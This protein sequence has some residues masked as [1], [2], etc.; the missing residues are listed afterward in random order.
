MGAS[1]FRLLTQ[2]YPELFGG[3]G[4]FNTLYKGLNGNG[5]SLALGHGLVLLSTDWL[6]V[7][8][9]FVHCD[10]FCIHGPSHAKTVAALN[11][12]IDRAND[13]G[14]LFNPTKVNPPSHR[15]KYCSFIYDT[16]EMPTLRNY[17]ETRREGQIS[18]LALSVVTGLLQFLVDPSRSRT[19]Q[20]DGTDPLHPRQRLYSDFGCRMGGFVVVARR[21][22][23]W[24]EPTRPLSRL[25]NFGYDLG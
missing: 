4:E 2:E 3:V 16:P 13:V 15:A 23:E 5:Y 18:R 21:F 24:C 6:P 12:L 10:Y 9:I 8:K 14:L 11:A 17:M 7:V 1:F 25:R 20:I 22:G 19:G